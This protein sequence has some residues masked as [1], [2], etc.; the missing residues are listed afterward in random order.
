MLSCFSTFDVG[1]FL[2]WNRN[3][4]RYN[5]Q[6]RSAMMDGTPPPEQTQVRMVT[7]LVDNSEQVEV[8]LDEL[9]KD[10]EDGFDYLVTCIKDAGDATVKKVAAIAQEYWRLGNLGNAK[11]V[12]SAG[13][14]SE[15]IA[16]VPTTFR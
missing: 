1:L 15:R 4:D 7:L 3:S 13:I 6:P 11:A 12:T 10:D 5:H 8:I 2:G 16:A 9:P 14:E